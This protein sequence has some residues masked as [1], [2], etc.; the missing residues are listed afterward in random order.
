MTVI[1]IKDFRSN[2]GKYLNLAANGE[3]V[4]LTSRAGSFKIVPVS[5]DD[6]LISKKEFFARVDQAR[7]DIAK[8]K[9]SEPAAFKKAGKLLGELQDHPKT[10]TGRPEALSGD[11]SGQWSRRISQKLESSSPASLRVGG[12]PR[13]RYSESSG[14]SGVSTS[15]GTSIPEKVPKYW[16][17]ASLHHLASAS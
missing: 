15:A 3:S 5:E 4:I 17:H 8:L 1:S 9:K 2:Q 13:R 6:S 14:I 12:L 11:R 7:K 10:G 16:T